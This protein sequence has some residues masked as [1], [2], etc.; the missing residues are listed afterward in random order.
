MKRNH[1]FCHVLALIALLLG[2]TLAVSPAFAWAQE[3]AVPGEEQS[4]SAANDAED[5]SG[6]DAAQQQSDHVDNL[7][8]NSWRYEDGAYIGAD[9]QNA[10][11]D[12]MADSDGY[13]TWSKKS[14]GTIVFSNGINTKG[15][16]GIGIDVSA[17]QGTINWSKVKASGIDFAIIRCGYGANRTKYDDTQF[18]NN[19]R[20]CQQNGIPFGI[21][22]YSY[23]DINDPM[24]QVQGEINHTLR[25]LDEA[26]LEPDDLALPVYYDLEDTT[27]EVYGRATIQKAAIAYCTALEDEGYRTGIYAS[28]NWW[29]SYLDSSTFDQWE[30]WIAQWNTTCNFDG[31]YST[32]QCTSSGK[33]NGISGRVDMNL[34]YADLGELVVDSNGTRFKFN[35][36]SYAKSQW[37]YF[38]GHWYYFK[39]TGYALAGGWA[40]LGGEHYYFRKDGSNIRGGWATIAGNRYYFRSDG[41]N[42]RGGWAT[43]SGK[44]YFFTDDGAAYRSGWFDVDG[45]KYYFADDCHMLSGE[46]AEID[47]GDYYFRSDGSFIK[48]GWATMSGKKYYFD[49]SG[50]AYR[51]KWYTEDGQKYYFS[52]VDCRMLANGWGTIAGDKYYFRSNGT[53]IK[54]GWATLSGRK[55][56]FDAEGVAYRDGWYTI[57]SQRYY[58]TE[59]CFVPASEFVE[60]DQ[61]LFYFRKDGTYLRG[62]WGTVSGK[63][64]YF[65]DSGAALA[66]GWHDIDGKRYYFRANGSAIAGGWA[67]FSGRRAYF[68]TDGSALR[69]G[70]A[71]LSGSRYYFGDDGFAYR[72]SHTI[73]GKT[74]YFTESGAMHTGWLRW[75]S[76]GLWSYFG[77]DGV[78]YTGTRTVDGVVYKFGASGRIKR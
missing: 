64:Y 70:W 17:H 18:I 69:G 34:I 19:V 66:D 45:I 74:Y 71:V 27:V 36:G 39:S 8:L 78:M 40:V 60:T 59:D 58:F 77:S 11:I 38:D 53:V 55:C 62:G 25:L 73:D 46:W 15:A 42:I 76:D 2:T 28:L 54:G 14:N 22:L 52:A 4:E 33:V 29:D 20:G 56:Y 41:T 43:M 49:E 65:E 13:V 72:Y 68:R 32:W 50:V 3:E 57:D 75:N 6:E 21:Y 51:G 1:S 9:G 12:L 26:G 24:D 37:L 67:T 5:G 7:P 23:G 30:R 44:K 35:N 10:G 61:G 63:K 48:G 47:G 31:T 16:V